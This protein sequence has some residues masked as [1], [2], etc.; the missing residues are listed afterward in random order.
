MRKQERT[1]GVIRNKIGG[2]IVGQYLT[3]ATFQGNLTVLEQ[4]ARSIVPF[5]DRN[6][7]LPRRAI[8][9]SR[10]TCYINTSRSLSFS[11]SLFLG[12]LLFSSTIQFAAISPRIFRSRTEVSSATP[13]ILIF[14]RLPRNFPSLVTTMKIHRV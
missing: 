4:A 1:Y 13:L 3:V 7:V 12:S 6:H 14:L 9:C 8:A 11:F 2:A 5:L 10:D